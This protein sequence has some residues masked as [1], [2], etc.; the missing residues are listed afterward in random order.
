MMRKPPSLRSIG[1]DCDI[2]AIKAFVCDHPLE[3]VDGRAHTF[4]SSFPFSCRELIYS[5]PPYLQATRRY[6]F[7]DT[8]TNSVALL[9][10]FKQLPCQVMVSG[11]A[12]AL[13]DATLVS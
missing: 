4:L 3:L 5:N 2:Q 8:K 7:D 11:H 6:L 1:I 10:L 12:S 13:Y 9:D